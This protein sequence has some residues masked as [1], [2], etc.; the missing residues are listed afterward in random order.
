[1][2]TTMTRS[3]TLS[4]NIICMQYLRSW[5]IRILRFLISIQKTRVLK[6]A[7]NIIISIYF[8]KPNVLLNIMLFF[9]FSILKFFNHYLVH[10]ILQL[11]S[12]LFLLQNLNLL[13][14]LLLINIMIKISI[15][16]LQNSKSTLHPIY[17]SI[18]VNSM[19][20][21]LYDP[22]ILPHYQHH[23]FLRCSYVMVLHHRKTVFAPY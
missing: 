14:L 12:L 18:Q 22:V 10:L 21:H 13:Y 17:H 1:M 5:D 3:N 16:Y 15:K 19:V 11:T 4:L 8:L 23:D 6:T 2:K 20:T 7:T 9:F